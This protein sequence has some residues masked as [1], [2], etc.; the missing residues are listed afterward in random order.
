VDAASDPTTHR[1]VTGLSL[2]FALVY[3][4]QGLGSP[5]DGLLVQP[6]MALL[7]RDGLG[8]EGISRFMALAALPWAVKPL[9]GLV[10]D[11]WPLLGRRRTGW[12]VLASAAATAAFFGLYA[13]ERGDSELA[14]LLVLLA[15]ATLGVAFSDVVI[16]A[17][18]VETGQPLGLTG[19]LQAVQWA[20]MY[21]ATV[22]AGLVGGW[23]AEDGRAPLAFLLSGSF[24]GLSLVLAVV[25]LRE[26]AAPTH[27]ARRPIG[28]L[29]ALRRPP[30]PA[31]AAFLALWSFN[32]FGATVQYV[33]WTEHLG[34]RES[35]YGLATSVLGVGALC[36]SAAYGVLARGLSRRALVGLTV[37]FGV[38]STLGYAGVQGEVHALLASFAVGFC[39]LI[40]SLTQLELAARL[41]PP[42]WAATVFAG[43]M[44]LSNVSLSAADVVGSSLYAAG[45]ARFGADTT[46]LGLVLAGAACTALCGLFVRA[47]GDAPA[48]VL[49]AGVDAADE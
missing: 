20:S 21:A 28:L 6:V 34:F 25:A 11:R 45:S 38:G 44:A 13:A 41:C 49:D 22:A 19:R 24:A 23:L 27:Q 7:V 10:S 16:D 1:R 47:L 12:L 48:P 39:Y 40:A 37:A 15:A 31:V 8:P 30:L 36:G 18:M 3:F 29:A 42:Q 43:L 17:L 33:H 32:P 2:L 35:F 14:L 46:Y 5:S 4:V 26:P 9:L